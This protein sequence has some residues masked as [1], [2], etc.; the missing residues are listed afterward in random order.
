VGE[1]LERLRE[2]SILSAGV[3]V[4]AIAVFVDRRCHE[5]CY[6]HVREREIEE[7]TD[8]GDNIVVQETERDVNTRLKTELHGK[9]DVGDIGLEGNCCNR[10]LVTAN[11]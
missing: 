9:F 8:G 5:L 2:V 4:A 6:C 1:I 10:C 3:V 11:C 7:C